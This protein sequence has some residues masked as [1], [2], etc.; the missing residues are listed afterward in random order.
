MTQTPSPILWSFPIIA[1]LPLVATCVA[2]A[3]HAPLCRCFQHRPQHLAFVASVGSS[4]RGWLA[5]LGWAV[6]CGLVGSCLV[7]WG[8]EGPYPPAPPPRP[9][10][11]PRRSR[12]HRPAHDSRAPRCMPSTVRGE[13]VVQRHRGRHGARCVH[14]DRPLSSR[15]H[16]ASN[17]TR[18]ANIRVV[19]YSSRRSIERGLTVGDNHI[20]VMKVQISPNL[21][22]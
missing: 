9:H 15:A 14:P 2:A 20:E 1:H 4:V 10:C 18:A 8:K 12:G 13:L 11:T 17:Y 19:H 6:A 7:G 3:R 22:M 21:Y 5:P 16:F